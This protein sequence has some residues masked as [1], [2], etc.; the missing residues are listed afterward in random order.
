MTGLTA[1]TGGIGCGKSVVA[2]IL[3]SLGHD[4]YD[5]DT[6]AKFLM[7]SSLSIKEQIAAEICEEAILPSGSIDRATLAEKVFADSAKL[8]I[9]NS[10]VHQAVR[11][12]IQMWAKERPN[13]FIET[14]IL[15]QS[16]LDRMVDC[17][18]EV[19]APRHIRVERV[20]L[21]SSLTSEQVLARMKSQESFVAAHT[22]PN[23]RMIE[24][25]GVKPVLPQILR[26]LTRY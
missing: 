16:Q 3:R 26:L 15:Y 9:L 12:D 7:D 17:V 24:N 4:V 5:C 18:W 1:I 10:I 21:R 2:E 14:A 19:T 23:V 8:D 25:D 13:A 22:H 6:R 11:H 20:M